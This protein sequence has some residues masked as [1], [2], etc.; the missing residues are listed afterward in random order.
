[1]MSFNSSILISSPVVVCQFLSAHC[2]I[3]VKV[4]IIVSLFLCFN[5]SD[6][7]TWRWRIWV[8]DG[9]SATLSD[10]SLS[11]WFAGSFR[12][13]P[14]SSAV[15]PSRHC[16]ES[17]SILSWSQACLS[18]DVSG[19]LCSF[20]CFSFSVTTILGK[21]SLGSVSGRLQKCRAS[22][23]VENFLYRGFG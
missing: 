5:F 21:P 10:S 22:L 18:S 13:F 12:S 20:P 15:T 11:V 3:Q 6:W 23:R 8:A 2:L 19:L 16:G 1:M 4:S 9:T 17:A 7:S 14:S